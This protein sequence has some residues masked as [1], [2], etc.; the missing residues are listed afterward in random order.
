MVPSWRGR[1]N[2]GDVER[3]QAL[4]YVVEA[5]DLDASRRES[6]FRAYHVKHGSTV[7]VTT[8]F[9]EDIRLIALEAFSILGDIENSYCSAQRVR[10]LA[11]EGAVTLVSSWN[12]D[13]EGDF[14]I[15]LG[16]F[17]QMVDGESLRKD[18]EKVGDELRKAINR[19]ATEG[20]SRVPAT[21]P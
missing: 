19:Y 1:R 18:W 11:L 21:T 13:A 3:Q 14:Y 5:M 2:W 16:P 6:V 9:S 17:M 7:E 20:D 12:F 4:H 15:R 8:D 10:N